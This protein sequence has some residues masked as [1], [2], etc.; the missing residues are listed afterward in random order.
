MKRIF[1]LCLIAWTMGIAP[2]CAQN[3]GK[4]PDLTFQFVDSNGETIGNGSVITITKFET[5]AFGDLLMSTGLF[6]K[7]TS[8]QAASGTMSLDLTAMPSNT[9]VQCCAFGL[10]KNFSTATSVSSSRSV[11]PAGSVSD[12]QT[13][14]MPN[15][16]NYQSWKATLQIK[17]LETVTNEVGKQSAGTEVIGMGPKIT[18]NFVYADPTGI[19]VANTDN[20]AIVIARYSVNGQRLAGPTKG[21]NIVKFS[22]GNIIKQMVR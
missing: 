5:D 18:V 3:D 15:S 7:N 4:E 6:V 11:I 8:A 1:T 2:V 12:I 9:H 14:W 22:D 13:E 10:C 19:N 17:V 16:G 21:L 20:S